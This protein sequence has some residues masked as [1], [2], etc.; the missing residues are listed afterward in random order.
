[1]HAHGITHTNTASWTQRDGDALQAYENG[2]E[3][4]EKFVQNL[5]LFLTTFLKEHLPLIEGN[6][7]LNP[8]LV[9]ALS[10]LVRISY[11][12]DAGAFPS[13]VLHIFATAPSSVPSLLMKST[14]ASTSAHLRQCF[15]CPGV[16]FHPNHVHG[17]CMCIR[18]VEQ[19]C[20]CRGVQGGTGLL[21][22]I[23]T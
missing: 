23:C 11:V 22:S 8:A 3:E 6:T 15:N 20:C 7:E 12:Q 10:Y 13:R 19:R 16:A 4:D 2:S 9:S 14:Q 1:M 18:M 21:E 5:A 17:M